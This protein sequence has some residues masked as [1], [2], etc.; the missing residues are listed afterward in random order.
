[1]S[2]PQ[3]RATE[4]DD[5]TG[6]AAVWSPDSAASP[7]AFTL[8]AALAD[9]DVHL[10]AG[11]WDQPTRLYALVKTH[12]LVRAEPALARALGL[13]ERADDESLTPIEQEPPAPGQP[14]DDWLARIAWS[15]D[16]VGCAL[17]QE[18]LALPPS[19]EEEMP[20]RGRNAWVANHPKRR[21]VRMVV[22]VLRD[23]ART[24][25]LRVRGSADSDDDV[26]SGDDLVPRLADALAATLA[27]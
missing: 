23:G 8:V 13:D 24:S 4:P 27:D 6:P 5:V 21:E 7:S 15:K 20:K 25:I 14:L 16:V 1:M 22:G 19:A 18:V 10:A 11:G 12:E 17:A 3:Y 26:V 9:I 2:D